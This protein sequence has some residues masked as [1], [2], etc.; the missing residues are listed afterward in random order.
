MFRVPDYWFSG[1][2]G[3]ASGS[4]LWFDGDGDGL[5]GW[6]GSDFLRVLTF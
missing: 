1:R 2:A 4:F 5:L 6:G 3:R